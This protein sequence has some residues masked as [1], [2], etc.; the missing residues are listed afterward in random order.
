MPLPPNII[1]FMV[2]QLAAKWLSHVEST[3]G[4]PN[5]ARLRSS[6][7]SFNNAFTSNPVCCASR[8]TIATGL[9][10]RQHGVLEN[11]YQLDPGLPTFMRTLQQAGWRTGAFGKLHFHPHFAG[12]RPDYRE[13]GFDDCEVTEDMRGGAWLDWVASEHPSHLDAALATVWQPKVPE[14]A[15]YGAEGR[16][17]RA[18]IESIRANFP[19]AS[20]EFPDAHAGAYPLPFPEEISQTNWITAKAL[21]FLGRADE[22]PFLA[23]I[24]YVQPHGP[25]CAPASDLCRIPEDIIPTPLEAEWLE[26]PHAPEYFARQRPVSGNWRH[27]RRCYFADLLHLDRQMGRVLDRLEDLQIRDHTC[28]L[29]CSDHGDLLYDHGFKGKEER[30]YDACIRVPLIVSGPGFSTGQTRAD[31]V[32]LEDICPTILELAGQ[33]FPPPV[34]GPDYPGPNPVLPGISLLST[35]RGTDLREA[36]YC[37][38]YNS[39]RSANP[40]DWARTIRTLSHRYTWYPGGGEQLFDLSRD[41]EEQHNLAGC[42]RHAALKSKLKEMLLER[43]VLQDFPKPRHHLF[44]LGVH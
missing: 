24:S 17:L 31:L 42:A 13:Y 29:F 6:G 22:R 5:V 36:V 18:R 12:L 9:S 33:Q 28:I 14:F 19:W 43:I 37:E 27:D 40:Q 25:Y 20:A 34:T 41:P 15:S 44:A 8:A 10:S 30:H 4:L 35:L 38:S 39:I 7:V 3:V 32:Q 11:G 1:L 16:N 21:D 2:D 23:Q 26:D